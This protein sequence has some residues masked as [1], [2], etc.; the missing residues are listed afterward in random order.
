MVLLFV[1]LAIVMQSKV[2][3]KLSKDQPFRLELL[4]ESERPADANLALLISC[5][6]AACHSNA[7]TGVIVLPLAICEGSCQTLASS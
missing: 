1:C 6:A 5:T 7:S 3:S 2:F 4:L